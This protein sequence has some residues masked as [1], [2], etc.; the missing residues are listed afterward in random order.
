VAALG[1]FTDI[2]RLMLFSKVRDPVLNFVGLRGPT[3]VDTDILLRNMEMAGMVF[4]G[5]L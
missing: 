5:A 2:Y 4:R 3:K 1:Y